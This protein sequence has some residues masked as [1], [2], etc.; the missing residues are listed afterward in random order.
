[1]IQK[2]MNKEKNIKTNKM[3]S[4]KIRLIMKKKLHYQNNKLNFCKINYQT[5]KK[6]QK[7]TIK[8]MIHK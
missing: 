2:M 6:C 8:N 3:N 5:Y 7:L 1:M 4:L